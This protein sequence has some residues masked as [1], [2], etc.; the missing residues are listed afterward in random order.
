[1]C[2]VPYYFD[3][4]LNDL[5]PG[6][7]TRREAMLQG[8]FRVDSIY[9]D[10]REYFG[11]VGSGAPRDRIFRSIDDYVRKTPKRLTALKREAEA[12]Q[13]AREATRA[14]IFD[15]TVGRVFYHMLYLGE[16]YRLAVA[17]GSEEVARVVRSRLE[18]ICEQI[19][20][21]ST[22]QALPLQQVVAVQVGTGL[23]ALAAWRE[24]GGTTPPR[25]R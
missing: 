9:H 3:P 5:T 11:V 7:I 6:G 25:G 14:E 22:L 18:D 10:I 20:G 13:Y 21:Q 2:E 19:D 24:S 1:V 12:P 16:V 4:A 23:H 15:V 17:R 8:V